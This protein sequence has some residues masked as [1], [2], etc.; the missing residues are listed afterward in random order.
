[1][2]KLDL[3]ND[4]GA[5]LSNLPAKQFK[6]IVSSV[7]STLKNPNAHDKRPITGLQGYYRV[8]IGEYRIVFKIEGD[9]LKIPIIGKRNGDEVYRRLMQKIK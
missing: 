3:S 7:L 5:F 2:L 9:I 8:G 4:A 6:Q 1:M